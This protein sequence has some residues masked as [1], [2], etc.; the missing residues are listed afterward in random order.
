[1][2]SEPYTRKWNPLADLTAPLRWRKPQ[3]VRVD[4]D[5]FHD[6]S[7]HCFKDRVLAVMALS[8]QHKFQVVT[9]EPERMAEHINEK[10]RHN[11]IELAGM[12]VAPHLV[13]P[14][15]GKHR[16]QQ[17]PLPNLWLGVRAHD[18]PSADEAIPWLL[19]CP[20]AVRFVE[21]ELT[22]PVTMA[23][24]CPPEFQPH[25]RP[26]RI[27]WVTLRGGDKPVHPDWVRAIRDQCQG[28][29]VAFWFSSWG[30]WGEV[31]PLSVPQCAIFSDGRTCD[32][33][34]AEM[35][36]LD[37][38]KTI[39]NGQWMYRV[40]KARSGRLLDGVEWNQMPEVPHVAD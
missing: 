30:A 22:G 2:Q 11:Q 16:F 36:R 38:E 10:D 25:L 4:M 37:N 34:R 24:K 35:R 14:A 1:M 6:H 20:A 9:W 32:G 26:D 21:L 40:G 19:R 33:T 27:G 13:D 17:L 8:P 28:A 29:G 18:Q 31:G 7:P 3:I 23:V 12:E 39:C 5:L 15:F